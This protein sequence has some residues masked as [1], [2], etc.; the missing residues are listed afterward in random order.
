MSLLETFQL[1]LKNILGL[2]CD[3]VAG[4][5]AIPCIKRNA[6]GAVNAVLCSD[7]ALAGITSVIPFDEVVEAMKNVGR[8]MHPDLRETARG[9]LAATPTARR[10]AEKIM[11]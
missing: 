10:I 6:M 9:G 7:M 3:P 8:M 2:V 4:L 5:V 1:A 11:H